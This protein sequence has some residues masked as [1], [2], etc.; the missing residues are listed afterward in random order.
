[1]PP[2]GTGQTGPWLFFDSLQG[3][4]RDVYAVLADGSALHRIT[5]SPATERE[6]AVSPDGRT[7]A[8]SS[9]ESG[10]FQI[11][12]Y[13]LPFGPPRQVTIAPKGAEQ[14]AW[15]PTGDRLAYHNDDGVWVVNV[16]G[17]G[18]RSVVGM[19]GPTSQ[20]E[21][22][23]FSP[24]GHGLIFDRFNQIHQ[25]DLDSGLETSIIQN[26]TTIIEHPSVSP[27]GRSIA[28]DV[29]CFGDTTLSIWIAPIAANTFV[30]Q[31]GARITAVGIGKARFPSFSPT[32]L[33]AFEHGDGNAHVAVVNPGGASSD[34]TAGSDDRNPS[35]SPA[36]LMLP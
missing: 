15:S 30:C 31:G 9:D 17:S 35:W 19:D 26:T 16:D 21:H 5:T 34:V 22:P 4:N 28:Y 36:S 6:P 2:P 33:I 12:L 3:L 13:P 8:Y 25:I 29:N 18:T 11:V 1:M 27:D 24:S 7:L 14:P 23:V 32:G 10:S 20:N